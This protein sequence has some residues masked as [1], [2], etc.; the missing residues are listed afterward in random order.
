MDAKTDNNTLPYKE[1]TVLVRDLQKPS[2]L[3]YWTDLLI[4]VA[5]AA[6]G[7]YFTLPFPDAFIQTPVIAVIGTLITIFALYRATYFNH[8]LAHQSH[9][10]PGFE[11]GWN[12]LIGI[13]LLIPSFLYSDHRNH[14]SVDG[15]GTDSDVEYFPPHLRGLRGALLLLA[16][17][18]AL[19]LIYITR[20]STLLIAAWI[21]PK[22]RAWVDTHASSLGILGLSRRAAPTAIE[23]RQWRIQEG[24]CF[25]YL[26]VS[27]ALLL[28]GI[29]PL[30]NL[31]HFYIILFGVL[32]LHSL[33]I[34]VGHR[35]E[36]D[37]HHSGRTD[38]IVDSFNF[39]RNRFVTTAL[40][41][42]G[43]NLHALHHLFPTLP[44]H[45]M[46]EAHR[47]IMAALP[48]DSLYH[49]VAS[50]SFFRELLRFLM[51][52][53]TPPAV[54]TPLPQYKGGVSG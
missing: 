5:A 48:Q 11:I 50:E 29:M 46:P 30:W 1:L 4:C 49:A 10:L 47:R 2:A 37:G 19:P 7:Y 15:F 54:S 35:Y 3:F 36:S 6:I 34:M 43:F 13:P 31:V 51:R 20:F 25:A 39:T 8:E 16:V 41:P 32:F 21:N 42:L 18:A 53:D 26:M 9:N 45:N 27:L 38:Q 17:S 22:A 23:R 44:Y 24:A 40:A 33:R 52:H 28:T 14:H 12:V